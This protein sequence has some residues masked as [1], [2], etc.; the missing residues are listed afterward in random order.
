MNTMIVDVSSAPEIMVL[1]TDEELS[2]GCRRNTGPGAIWNSGR[3]YC[4][5]FVNKKFP[6][7]RSHN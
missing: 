7:F 1:R 6:D 4:Y 3:G 5:G 2:D